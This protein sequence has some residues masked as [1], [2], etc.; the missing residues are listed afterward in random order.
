MTFIDTSFDIKFLQQKSLPSVFSEKEKKQENFL[1]LQQKFTFA[2]LRHLWCPNSLQ[3]N[4]KS[5][6]RYSELKIEK[7]MPKFKLIRDRLQIWL[8]ILCELKRIN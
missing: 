5:L 1:Q 4:R 8:L 6:E 7:V 3:N 2:N